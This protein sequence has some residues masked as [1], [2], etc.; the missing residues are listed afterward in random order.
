MLL[1]RNGALGAWDHPLHVAISVCN[2]PVLIR[3][4]ALRFKSDWLMADATG[5]RF[6][7]KRLDFHYPVQSF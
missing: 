4:D 3:A 5:Y 7:R 2:L 1:R 6:V